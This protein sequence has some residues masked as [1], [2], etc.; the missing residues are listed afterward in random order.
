MAFLHGVETIELTSGPVSVT[1]VRSGVI[2]LV[3]IAPKGPINTLTLVSSQ[4]DAAQFGEELTGFSIP[5][6]LAAI[7]ANGAATVLVV[8]VFDPDT[9]VTAVT[10][11]VLT[12]VASRK[13]KL[14]FAPV[15]TTPVIKD[16]T[17]VTTYVAGTDYTIDDFG[18]ITILAAIGTIAEGAV[19]H[20]TYEKLDASA[21]TAAVINGTNS[22]GVR[23]GF[24]CF[25]DAY[26][27]FGFRPKIL[28][29]P[30]YS[31]V[32]AVASAMISEA[33]Y[34]KAVCL[35]DAPTATTVAG[36]ITARGPAGTLNF[37]TSSDR[38][39][40]LEPGNLKAYDKA[41]DATVN[42]PFS[43]FYA[44]V[45]AKNDETNGYWTSPSNK[46]IKGTLNAAEF[47]VTAAINDS[48]TEANQLN[49]IGICT[50]FASGAS[51]LR[52]WGN[53]SAAFPS[54][55]HVKNFIPVR[56][57]A[58]IVHESIEEAMLQFQDEPITDGVIDSVRLTVQAFINTLIGRGALYPGS[59][60]LFDQAKNPST[61]LAAGQAVW[62]VVFASPPPLER[63]TFESFIDIN[64]IK[65]GQAS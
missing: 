54:V 63:M 51:G 49:A 1:V 56:R 7:Q 58:D 43:Q 16:V 53:R 62:T 10:S 24:K 26:N 22:G 30:G 64:L 32:N 19:L 60:V 9:M 29:A 25:L 59:T 8:N 13:T 61:Q 15:G 42:R 40:L 12:A 3:G 55:T 6:A 57:T 17:D 5:Q 65:V 41:T 2:G 34:Y 14:A 33:D 20:A 4:S 46:E 37:Y 18:N 35:L 44:G 31:S 47:P 39:I 36:A 48:T 45:M 52:T 50:V 21:I 11:E 23:T 28:I 38:A 27:S